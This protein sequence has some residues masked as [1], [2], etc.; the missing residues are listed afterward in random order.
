MAM[1]EHNKKRIYEWTELT[2]RQEVSNRSIFR[3]QQLSNEL[4]DQLNEIPLFNECN[5]GTVKK[6]LFATR[7]ELH[8]HR[9]E[10]SQD[11]K[12][13]YNFRLCESYYF[14]KEVRT[15]LQADD[16]R[17]DRFK[18]LFDAA[19]IADA[20]TKCRFETFKTAVNDPNDGQG[21]RMAVEQLVTALAVLP[22]R[23]VLLEALEK[24]F[25]L[26]DEPVTRTGCF[27][28]APEKN[29]RREGNH[30]FTFSPFTGFVLDCGQSTTKE[31]PPIEFSNEINSNEGLPG[32]LT[33]LFNDFLLPFT[34]AYDKFKKPKDKDYNSSPYCED[35]EDL[36]GFVVPAY[37]IW[38]D[39]QWLGGM[40]GWLV[41]CLEPGKDIATFFTSADD[42]EKRAALCKHSWIDFTHLVRTYVRRVREAHMRDLLEDYAEMSSNIPPETFFEKHIHEIIGWVKRTGSSS[43]H[44]GCHLSEIDIP[45]VEDGD[46]LTLTVDEMPDTKWSRYKPCSF[47]ECPKRY[48]ESCAKID[49]QRRGC[50]KMFPPGTR[51]LCKLFLEELKLIES[52]RK[53][54]QQSGFLASAHDYSKDIGSVLLRLHEFKEELDHS[55]ERILGKTKQLSAL[56]GLPATLGDDIAKE[57]VPWEIP[58]LDWFA[59]V[60]FT[61]AHLETQTRGVLIPEPIE[62]LSML[63]GGTLR[64][65]NELVRILVWQPIPFKEV[66]DRERKY[67][68]WA[69]EKLRLPSTWSALFKFDTGTNSETTAFHERLGERVMRLILDEE[70]TQP[71]FAYRFPMPLINPECDPEGNR[72]ILWAESASERWKP[73]DGLL[74]LFVFSMRFAFQCAW[75]KTILEEPATALPIVIRTQGLKPGKYELSICFPSPLSEPETELGLLP[76]HTEWRH[77][78]GHYTDRQTN[79]WKAQ[80]AHVKHD[81]RNDNYTIT[82]QALR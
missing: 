49:T 32:A 15:W 63:E 23:G 38:D 61:N 39:T 47:P 45:L 2:P 73:L 64:E 20:A 65:I 36:I 30:E 34:R 68:K 27:Y 82:L 50:G 78:I 51:R 56:D 72:S 19:K 67:K 40:A 35:N 26:Y 52:Q 74:P 9:S 58:R 81:L 18:C 21:R 41:I 55:K 42:Q 5:I 22:Y 33:T 69:P 12:R 44:R 13:W 79:P 16:T 7:D 11:G 29:R 14:P 80:T 25:C 70:I 57:V 43:K 75:A 17:I 46:S 62:C 76:Y 1:T 10:T 6:V 66:K 8:E 31:M 28:F 71:T 60:R 53:R 4:K 3:V 37:D 54:G 59:G 48:A 77:Q 24:A